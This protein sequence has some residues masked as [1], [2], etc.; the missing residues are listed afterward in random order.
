M[1][2][3]LLPPFYNRHKADLKILRQPQKIKDSDKI[4][5]VGAKPTLKI[6]GCLQ[7]FHINGHRPG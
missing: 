6:Q 3:I 7:E 2:F 5:A 4:W 1:V